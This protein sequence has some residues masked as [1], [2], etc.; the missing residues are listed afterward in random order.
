MI[1]T[2]TNPLFHC[3]IFVAFLGCDNIEIPQTVVQAEK[4]LPSKIDF[5]IHV[6]PILSDKCF[7]CHGPD[8]GSRKAGL[9]LDNHRGAT[10]ELPDNPGH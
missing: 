7:A 6:K 5:N 2:S 1:K 9:R 8:R 4:D 3:L 10:S